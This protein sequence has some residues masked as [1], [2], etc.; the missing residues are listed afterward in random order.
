MAV[1]RDR[2]APLAAVTIH[3]LIGLVAGTMFAARTLLVLAGCVVVE[4]LF[5]AVIYGFSAGLWALAGLVA[6]QVGYLVGIGLRAALER[7][8]VAQTSFHPRRFS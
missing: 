1:D 5:F 2:S 4:C 3:F 6:V 8:G 7:L